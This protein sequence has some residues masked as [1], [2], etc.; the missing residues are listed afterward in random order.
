ML[1]YSWTVGYLTERKSAP[2]GFRRVYK[3]VHEQE[4]VK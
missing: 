1:L 2:L 4:S 3:K